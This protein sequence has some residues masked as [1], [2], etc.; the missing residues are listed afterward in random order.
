MINLI[1]KSKKNTYQE[2]KDNYTY[3]D[4]KEK[5][6]EELIGEDCKLKVLNSYA[7]TKSSQ[8]VTFNTL[9]CDFTGRKQEDL[10]DKYQEV[11]VVE[12]NEIV[13]FG[14]MNDYSFKEMRELDVDTEIEMTILSPMKLATLRTV[15]LMGTYRLKDLIAKIL[16]PLI[17]DGFVIEELEIA[18]RTVTVNYP[19]DT[20]EYC[21]NNLSN[22][23][24]FWWFVDEFKRIYIKDISL[25]LTKT[26]DY[27]YDNTHTIP[28]LQYIKPTVSS[29]GYANVVNF[30]NVRLY[31]YSNL[32]MNDSTINSS[33]NPLIE[34]QITTIKK[35][36]QIAFN[37]P[38]DI[39]SAN[40]IKSGTSIGKTDKQLYPYL[41]G[42]HIKGTYSNL[43]TFELYIRYNQNTGE[44][45]KSSNMGFEG[46]EEDT[47]KE[48][49][50]IRDSFFSN[51]ITGLKYNNEN[52]NIKSIEEISSDSAL[53]WSIVRMYNDEA[54]IKEKG[55]ISNTG[56]IET[57]EDMKESWKTLQELREIGS[58]YINKN[59]LK[60]DG[61]LELKIDTSCDMQVGNTVKID[62][63]LFSGT[64]IITKIQLSIVNNENEWI[65]T[66]KNGNMLNNFIDIFRS[67]N[68]QESEEKTYKISVT[69]YAEEKINEKFEVVK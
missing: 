66:C 54:I 59:S 26:P 46:K 9:T 8:E 52:V 2:I 12:D 38:C 48:F 55:K 36:G 33:Y 57:T 25:M 32:K 3:R 60:L 49:L 63:L 47:E 27:I 15:I 29:E 16:Q 23:F 58:S 1:Y 62:K 19:L 21:M 53:I 7:I 11:K 22:K 4:L 61:E 5:T 10:P 65:I 18:D 14:Y 20:I 42:L 51:L 13:F 35:D 69:H 56:I 17:D 28:Y 31:E 44:Y 24:E 40:I 68:T 45:S 64:Y 37:Y 39:T 67:E 50:L 41:Y 6:Y 34:G 30:K 43:E